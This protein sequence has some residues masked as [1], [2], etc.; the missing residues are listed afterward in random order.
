MDGPKWMKL[1]IILLSVHTRA[2]PHVGISNDVRMRSA[3]KRK[4][5][6][7]SKS[8]KWCLLV[9]DQEHSDAMKTA[10]YR[11][12]GLAIRGIRG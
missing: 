12:N 5:A 8:M 2:T 11:Q 3:K 6:H 1:T 10:P 7:K 4:M 9:N